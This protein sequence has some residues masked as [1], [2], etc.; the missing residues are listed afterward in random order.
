MSALGPERHLVRPSDLVAFRGKADIQ[1]RARNDVI[2]PERH[3]VRRTQMFA[4]G[5]KRK[6]RDHRKSVGLDP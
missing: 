4:S 5:V 3:L 6:S 1:T 2:D